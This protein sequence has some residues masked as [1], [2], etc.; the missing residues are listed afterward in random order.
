MAERRHREN[1]TSGAYEMGADGRPLRMGKATPVEQSASH[2]DACNRG[3]HASCNPNL[4]S[5]D[6]PELRPSKA[7]PTARDLLWRTAERLAGRHSDLGLLEDVEAYL[8]SEGAQ[9]SG[10]VEGPARDR[11][12]AVDQPSQ[13]TLATTT[14]ARGPEEAGTIAALDR[15]EELA[16]Q[17]LDNVADLRP[18]GLAARATS[19]TDKRSK[20][21]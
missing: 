9:T 8:R 2:C 20:A 19:D 7:S 6:C 15:I 16:R 5:C 21:T 12:A 4:C 11:K 3:D 10:G 1:V 13:A 14:P 18:L 17:V